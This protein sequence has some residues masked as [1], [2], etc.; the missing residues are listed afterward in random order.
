[1]V[2]NLILKNFVTINYKINPSR[3]VNIFKTIPIS[4]IS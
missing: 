3:S 1:M 2:N 4:I